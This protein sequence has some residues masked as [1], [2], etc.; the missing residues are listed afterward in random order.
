MF[1]RTIRPYTEKQVEKSLRKLSEWQPNKK[2]TEI[3]KTYV[4][5]NFVATLAFL[6]KITVHAEVLDHHPEVLMSYGKL[7]VTLKTDS[8][9]GLTKSDFDL[10]SRIDNLSR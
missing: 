10:A 2:S 4:F 5:P 6:A 3:S 1:K 8:A 9:K 7:K